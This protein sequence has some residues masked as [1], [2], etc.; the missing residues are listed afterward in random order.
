MGIGA[1][2]GSSGSG[3]AAATGTNAAAQLGGGQLNEN[4]FLQLLVAQLQYQNPLQPVSNTQFVTQLAQFQMLSVLQGIQQDVSQIVSATSASAA[5][6]KGTATG[7]QPAASGT[8]TG[9]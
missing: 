9:A 8:G 4:S 3:A 6:Q 2:G 5:A 1:V 7:G